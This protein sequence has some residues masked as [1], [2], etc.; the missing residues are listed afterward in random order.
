MPK[1]QQPPNPPILERE[2]ENNID[3]DDLSQ[4]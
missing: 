1:S 2:F 4:L 3:D